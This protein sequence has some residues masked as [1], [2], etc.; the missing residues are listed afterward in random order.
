MSSL[1][2]VEPSLLPL[3][4]VVVAVLDADVLADV[5]A[6]PL[7]SPAVLDASAPPSALDPWSGSEPQATRPTSAQPKP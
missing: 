7:P 3:A 6:P 4:V 2:V 5:V 1:P